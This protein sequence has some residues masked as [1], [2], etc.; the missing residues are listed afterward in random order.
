MNN[1]E[2]D[3]PQGFSIAIDGPVASGKGT[4]ATALAEKLGGFNLNTGAMYRVVALWCVENGINIES[5]Q[6]VVKTLSG[7]NIE[8]ESNIVKINGDDVTERIKEPDIADKSSIV[9]SYGGVRK[10]L[11][12]RQREIAKAEIREGKIVIVEGRDI[13]I[14]VLPDADLKLFLTARPEIR[15]GRRVEQYRQRGVEKSFEEMLEDVRIR[16][17]RDINR[18]VDPLPSNPATLGYW[19]LDNSDQNESETIETVLA[20]LRKRGLIK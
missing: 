18:S 12:N 16:D 7:I 6:E 11:A 1:S 15:A 8:L 20:Q 9:A 17:E 19:V 4:L 5:E 10:N 3:K 13:G 14:R 2:I